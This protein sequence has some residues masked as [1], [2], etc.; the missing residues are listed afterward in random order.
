M[1]DPIRHVDDEDIAL[2]ARAAAQRLDRT[3]R[4]HVAGLHGGLSPVALA[5]AGA[6]WLLNL[7]GSPA[8]AGWLM[9]RAHQH[10]MRAWGQ[11]MQVLSRPAPAPHERQ[12]D[13]AAPDAPAWM[14]LPYMAW[15]RGHLAWSDW[16]REAAALP[17][18]APHHAD[19]VGFFGRQWLDMLSPGHTALNPEVQQALMDSRGDNLAR[20]W[21]HLHDDWRQ[22]YGL[23]PVARHG[24][25]AGAAHAAQAALPQPHGERVSP[26]AGGEGAG[27]A[28]AQ[29]KRTVTPERADDAPAWRPG[30]EVAVTPGAVVY[31]NHLIELIQYEPATSEVD[32]EPI[33]IVPSWIM[34]YYILDLSPHNSMVRWLVGQGHTVFMLSWRNPDADDAHLSLD[35]YL[36]LGILDALAAMARI[37]PGEQVHAV[38]YCLGGTLLAIAA[39]TL[40]RPP[41][42]QFELDAHSAR[43]Q[44]CTSAYAEL[45]RLKTLTL[46][47]AQVDFTEPGEIGVLIDDAQV[48]WLEDQMAERG[49]LSGRQM[50]G[51]FQF[52]HARELVYSRAMREYLLGEREHPNDLMAWN[53]DVTRMPATMHSQYLRQLFLHNDLAEGRYQVDGRA[54][55]LRDLRMPMFVVGTEK[56]HVCPWQSVHKIHRLVEAPVTFVLASGGHNAGIVSEPGHSRRSYRVR[57]AGPLDAWLPPTDWPAAATPH[58]G[59]WWLRWQIWLA[60]HGSRRVAARAVDPGNALCA[61]PGR[62]VTVRYDD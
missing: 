44:A 4:A 41:L 37:V 61:A 16:L 6:D 28:A 56:D 13:A 21:R 22:R 33:L 40:A 57:T 32:A 51:S 36:H 5:L 60:A 55:S 26:P 54:V 42:A 2:Q 8:T 38:G 30:V 48:E 1:L 9:T 27:P 14:S 39:A 12:P 58:E 53:A 62:Y 11:V 7:A 43:A 34:K 19:M 45:P 31:R 20:G 23:P 18:M 35:D 49:Y 17:G 25:P 46:L 3:L 47:A 59:S 52:L 15:A 24:G 10:G 29:G 50:A